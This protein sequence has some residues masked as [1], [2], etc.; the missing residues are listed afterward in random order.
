MSKSDRTLDLIDTS[1]ASSPQMGQ[2]TWAD[3]KPVNALDFETANGEPFMLAVEFD[4]GD[5][6][7]R[8]NVDGTG[9][10]RTLDGLSI[11]RDLTHKRMRGAINVWFNLNFDAQIALKALPTVNLQEIQATGGTDF[12]TPSGTEYRI[13]Y[14]AKKFLRISD[15][16]GNTY[17]HFDISQFA[18]G[19]LE[20]AAKTWLGDDEAKATPSVSPESDAWDESLSDDGRIRGAIAENWQEVRK[21]ARHDV[22]LTRR[23]AAE[24]IRVAETE[25]E[26]PIP[27]GKPISTGYM[28]ADFVKAH[29]DYKPGWAASFVQSMAWDAYA[30]GRFEIYERGKVGAVAGPDINSAYPWVMSELPDPASLDWHKTTD[31]DELRDGELGFVRATVTTD[32][33]R[34]IQPFAVKNRSVGRVEYPALDG[35]EVTTIAPTFLFAVDEGIVTDYEIQEAVVGVSTDVTRKPFDFLNDLYAK[36]KRLERE[37]RDKPAMLLKIVMNSLYGKTC[38]TTAKVRLLTPDDGQVRPADLDPWEQVGMSPF[39]EI[40]IIER[41]EAGKFFNP[42]IASYITGTTRLE[43]HKRVVEYGLE[44]DTYMLATDCIMIDAD[45]YDRSGFAELEGDTLGEWDFDYEGSDALVVASG[46]YEVYGVNG[47]PEAVKTK[48]RGFNELLRNDAPTLRESIDATDNADALPVETTRPVTVGDA[49][50]QGLPTSDIGIFKS[51]SRDLS[52]DMDGKRDWPAT[53]DWGDLTTGVQY[54]PPKVM[55]E[56][57]DL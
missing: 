21:Y 52:A 10:P 9:N 14:I 47:D 56:S 16:H 29:L 30:G 7:V 46:V 11:L 22:N 49:L 17:W 24:I 36:R 1:S 23:L 42:V 44:S 45:A 37:G 31:I 8:T 19:T 3:D 41:Y 40:P 20:S 5:G 48:A 38:Q 55:D 13:D 25:V 54:G 57:T 2:P 6:F 15:S 32:A 50:N 34:R 51:G 28:A 18:Y 4:D 12:V 27:M 26:P 35:V 53:V 39:G 33:D 43:L